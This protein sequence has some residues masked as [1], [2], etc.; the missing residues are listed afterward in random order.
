MSHQTPGGIQGS[1]EKN[2]TWCCR[3]NNPKYATP[4]AAQY[5]CC[6]SRGDNVGHSVTAHYHCTFL[7]YAPKEEVRKEKQQRDTSRKGPQ[8]SKATTSMLPT[9]ALTARRL[10]RPS[11]RDGRRRHRRHKRGKRRSLDSNSGARKPAI[12]IHHSRGGNQGPRQIVRLDRV[13][14]RP[15]P[16]GHNTIRGGTNSRVRRGPETAAVVRLKVLRGKAANKR[17]EDLVMKPSARFLGVRRK[18]P[19]GPRR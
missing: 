13:P 4:C 8:S 5:A 2:S 14:T 1:G 6:A 15:P 17:P 12:E 10:S 18:Q 7:S 11:S 19:D 9:L 3:R 16:K